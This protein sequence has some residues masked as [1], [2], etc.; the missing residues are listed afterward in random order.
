[1]PEPNRQHCKIALAGAPMVGKTTLLYRLE[2]RAPTSQL[3]VDADETKR[4]VHVTMAFP[5]QHLSIM[6]ASGAFVNDTVI[7]TVLTA[8]T[9][10]V[11]VISTGVHLNTQRLFFDRYVTC[12]AQV[13]VHWN[14]V[15][16]LFVLNIVEPL[17]ENPLLDQIPPSFHDTIMRCVAITEQGVDDIWQRML[18]TVES[19]L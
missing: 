12:A 8:A 3:T 18:A 9:M 15:P 17:V 16:W 19:R 14:D 10:V 2:R 7:P 13:G 6:A 1:M 4:I 5:Q 11:Y